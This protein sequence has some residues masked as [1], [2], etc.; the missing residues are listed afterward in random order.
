MGLVAD[1]EFKIG[2]KLPMEVSG[3]ACALRVA[4]LGSGHG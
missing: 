4:H 2:N 1:T 3:P